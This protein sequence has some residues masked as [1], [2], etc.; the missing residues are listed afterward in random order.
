MPEEG[1]WNYQ[2]PS[3]D[4]LE[5]WRSFSVGVFQWI[6][7]RSGGLKKSRMPLRIRGYTSEPGRVKEQVQAVVDQLNRFGLSTLDVRKYHYQAGVRKPVVYWVYTD[8]SLTPKQVATF[9]IN[10]LVGPQKSRC[11]YCESPYVLIEGAVGVCLQ[12]G[13]GF[14]NNRERMTE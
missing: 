3:S 12:C 13:D 8:T 10:E 11:P 9:L 5:R 2:M 4:R 6:C 7:A 1:Q 14:I